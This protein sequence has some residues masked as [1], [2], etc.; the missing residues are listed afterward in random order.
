MRDIALAAGMTAAQAGEL[1]N[2]IEQALML[3]NEATALRVV[4]AAIRHRCGHRM[5]PRRFDDGQLICAIASAWT[6]Q[7]GRR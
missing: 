7:E 6:A 3:D 4:R 1:C 5:L 2:A